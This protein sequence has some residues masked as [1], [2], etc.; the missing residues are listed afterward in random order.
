MGD[1]MTA[2]AARSER[3]DAVAGSLDAARGSAANL[4]LCGWRRAGRARRRGQVWYVPMERD[5]ET[6]A[7]A[8]GG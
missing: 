4:A 8:D 1:G 5:R 6:V 3:I 2:A 7:N